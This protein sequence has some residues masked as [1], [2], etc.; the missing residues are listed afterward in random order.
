MDYQRLRRVMMNNIDK[1]SNPVHRKKYVKDKSK[2]EL[3]LDIIG[4]PYT[5]ETEKK[6]KQFVIYPYRYRRNMK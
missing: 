5:E 1:L 3:L 6:L 4:F 2:R